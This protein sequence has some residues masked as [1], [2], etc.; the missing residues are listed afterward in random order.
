MI[1]SHD[2]FCLLL[3]K[4]MS[5]SKELF[6]TLLCMDTPEG[7]RRCM[8]VTVGALAH[9]DEEML[10]IKDDAGNVASVRYA[11]CRFAYEAELGSWG[12][13][14]LTG[15]TFEDV[16]VLVSPTGVQIA[17]GTTTSVVPDESPS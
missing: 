2:E 14:Y 10:A 8:S 17:V 6:V 3:N 9:V 13:S 1:S 7:P 15:R 12:A 4:W 5:E 16:F 11:E